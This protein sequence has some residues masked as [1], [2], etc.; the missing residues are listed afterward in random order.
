LRHCWAVDGALGLKGYLDDQQLVVGHNGHMRKILVLL[1]FVFSVPTF[2]VEDEP[3]IVHFKSAAIELSGE[4]FL[5]KG[6]GPFP[7]V[8]YNHGSAPGMLNSQA[9]KAMAPLYT[10][11]GWIFFMPY[12]RG[13]GLSSNAGNYIGDEMEN[14]F[15]A[16]G[17][18]ASAEKM[19][20]LLSGD[21][22]ADQLAA[23]RWLRGQK[24]VQK[25]RVAVAGNSF[26]GIETVFGISK[27]SYCAAVVASGGAETWAKAPSLQTLMKESVR[28][29][30]APIFFFQAEN[31]F[32]TSPSQVLSN[33]MKAAGKRY[34]VKIYP[35]FGKTPKDG[36]AFAYAGSSVWFDDVFK[37]LNMHCQ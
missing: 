26:G 16:G 20:A 7:A 9:S 36:H 32:D 23:L 8:L 19:I 1:I 30:N 22:L 17:E 35:A 37:F 27:E 29:A 25:D 18:K 2:A 28:N 21:H 11:K 14:A 5:P 34:E 31:D 15:K 4:L 13:Q 33:E 3:K 24:F 12:R 6:K 10:K